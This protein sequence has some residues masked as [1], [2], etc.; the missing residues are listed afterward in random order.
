M[1]NPND[2]VVSGM[3][4]EYGAVDADGLCPSL[5]EMKRFRQMDTVD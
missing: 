1:T 4:N 3:Q 2:F 5:G